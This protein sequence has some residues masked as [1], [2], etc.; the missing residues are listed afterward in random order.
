MMAL[1]INSG[2][3]FLRYFLPIKNTDAQV[4]IAIAKYTKISN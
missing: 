3:V 4:R 1:I 2:R